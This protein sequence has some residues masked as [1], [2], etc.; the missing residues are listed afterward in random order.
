MKIRHRTTYRYATPV[1]FKAH[2]LLLRPRDGFAVHVR[3]CDIEISPD[4]PVSWAEDALGNAVATANFSAMADTLVIESHVD[5]DLLAPPWPIFNIASSAVR[6][7]FSYEARDRRDLAPLMTQLP[8]DTSDTVAAWAR[9]FVAGEG[10]DS[11]S[12]LRDINFGIAQT[13]AYEAREP[14]G[15]QTAHETLTLGRGSCRDFAVLF[16]EA[17]RSL[18]FAAR[19]V[20]GYARVRSAGLGPLRSTHAWAEVFLPGGG[21]IPFDPTNSAM[22]GFDLV[23]VAIGRDMERIMPVTGSYIGPVGSY[24][25][26]TVE[27]YLSD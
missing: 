9:G 5:L 23:P 14:E 24:I 8:S 7:P 1:A 22:G 11:L 6:Y 18:G 4:A 3:R 25:G 27:I 12:L 21:W 20:S 2:R 26:L 10:T 13:F 15:T 16:A 19:L 17:V